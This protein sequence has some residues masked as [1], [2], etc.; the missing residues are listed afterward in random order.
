MA[1]YGLIEKILIK[2]WETNMN[3]IVILREFGYALTK[4]D[5]F[6]TLLVIALF[7]LLILFELLIIV[8]DIN[9]FFRFF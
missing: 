7:I 3:N 5:Y 6:Y 8:N 9:S 2:S 1:S 4:T